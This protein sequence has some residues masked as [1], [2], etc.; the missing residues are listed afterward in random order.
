MSIKHKSKYSAISNTNEKSSIP[1]PENT[2]LTTFYE[3]PVTSTYLIAFAISDFPKIEGHSDDLNDEFSETI[4][5]V[6]SRPHWINDT[7][8]TLDSGIKFIAEIGRYVGISY[9]LS[10]IDQIAIPTFGGAMEN[11]GLVVYT[12]VFE[13][14][15]NRFN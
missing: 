13:Y 1:Q 3:T 4:V 6:F 2:I 11:W 12:L 9:M 14:E 7:K 10:K 8:L 15:M 5:R